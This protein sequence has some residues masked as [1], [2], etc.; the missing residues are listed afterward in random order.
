MENLTSESCKSYN[1]ILK[2]KL[3]DFNNYIPIG[4]YTDKT[5][6]KKSNY[7]KAFEENENIKFPEYSNNCICTHWIKTQCYIMH[8]K[9]KE[10]YIVGN[11]CIKR[12]NIKKKC[13]NCNGLHNRTKFN[14]CA[15]CEKKQKEDIRE[16]KKKE[17]EDI[18][19]NKKKEKEKIKLKYKYE[20]KKT[21]LENKEITFGKYKYKTIKY[22]FD[23]DISYIHWCIS[24]SKK[25]DS[26][27]FK[28]IVKYYQEYYE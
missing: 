16:N 5:N 10:I 7:M 25:D 26:P 23:N 27:I 22:L 2:E 8:I 3:G 15:K 14:I 1:E 21:K 12:F 11:C 18:R 28:D 13:I 17:K 9:T 19:E 6:T 4:G 20:L 24:Q